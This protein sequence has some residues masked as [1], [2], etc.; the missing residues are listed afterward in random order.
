MTVKRGREIAKNQHRDIPVVAAAEE[1]D[2]FYARE[3][4]GVLAL[5]YAV[6]RRRHQAEDI[7]QEAFFRAYRDWDRIGRLDYRE[8]WIRRVAL[9]LS[10]SHLRRWRAEAKALLR[11]GAPGSAPDVTPETETYWEHVR[12]LPQRQ[13]QVVALSVLEDRSTA[14]IAG[15][16]GIEESTVRVHLARGRATLA[17]ALGEDYR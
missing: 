10:Y 8:A 9:N 14:D 17:S 7:A 16:L 1:F 13:A 12:S 5:C 15:L 6:T 2:R 4:P 11:L 3:L